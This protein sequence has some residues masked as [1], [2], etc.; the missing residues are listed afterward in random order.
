MTCPTTKSALGRLYRSLLE[1][2][3]LKNLADDDELSSLL[4]KTQRVKIE[5]KLDSSYFMVE[6]NETRSRYSQGQDKEPC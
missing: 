2:L 6:T 3:S 1:A 5:K 4:E